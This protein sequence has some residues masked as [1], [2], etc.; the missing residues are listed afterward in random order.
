MSENPIVEEW[1]R[2]KAELENNIE[3][4][5]DRNDEEKETLQLMLHMLKN[6]RISENKK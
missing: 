1:V 4:L 2:K 5:I 6:S 3:A